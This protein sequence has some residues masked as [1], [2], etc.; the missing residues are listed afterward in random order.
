MF[1]YGFLL[2]RYSENRKITTWRFQVNWLIHFWDWLRN[3]FAPIDWVQ[4]ISAAYSP[5][6][7]YQRRDDRLEHT[8]L[9]T[10]RLHIISKIVSFRRHC[11]ISRSWDDQPNRCLGRVFGRRFSEGT[12]KLRDG[13]WIR[14]ESGLS[15]AWVTKKKSLEWQKKRVWVR[16]YYFLHEFPGHNPREHFP[17]WKL[18]FPFF[19]KW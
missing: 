12:C 6:A 19:P 18:T 13:S 14:P 10:N 9:A 4:H 11:L 3:A 8:S 1:L 2:E 7:R 16:L 17:K 5:F 15:Q